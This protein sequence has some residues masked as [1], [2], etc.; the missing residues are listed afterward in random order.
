MSKLKSLRGTYDILP[1]EIEL[2]VYIESRLKK[3]MKRFGYFQIRTP[4]IEK[5]EVFT[6]S[7]GKET[8]IVN[9]EM[10]TFKDVS[11][12]DISL[13]PEATAG[14]VRAYIEHSMYK[15]EEISKFYYFGPMFRKERPQTGRSRQF[16]QFGVEAIGSGN[17]YLDTEIVSI[18]KI[19]FEEIG[20][21]NYNL[22]INTLGCQKDKLYIAELLK[23][24][25]RPKSSKLCREC[26][27][28]V[29]KNVFRVLDCKNKKCIQISKNLPS[30][31]DLICDKCKKHYSDFKQALSLLKIKY[32][33]D[34]TIVRGLDYYTGPVFE[35]THPDLGAQNAIAA[36]GRYDNLVQQMGGPNIEAVGFALGIERL[37][38]CLN[39]K[40]TL[41]GKID[42]FI[43]VVDSEAYE[44][45]F[46]FLYQ[47][48]KRGINSDMDYRT[49]SMKSQM[50]KAGKAGVKY[51][52]LIGKEEL[53][54]NKISIK[55]MITGKQFKAHMDKFLCQIEKLI[56]NRKG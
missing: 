45:A 18:L 40:I 17:P 33:H 28:R 49:S 54:K 22:K 21:N 14:V 43:V 5:T 27:Q 16:Y 1:E 55:D 30:I 35:V 9:K 47:L 12:N 39:R 48:R 51:V 44:C 3:L 37:I 56:K 41:K 26:K 38:L 6:K 13:R 8:D 36:G 32:I 53:D 42:I 31:Q 19:F 34:N 50:R 4:I 52:A 25:L 15:K 2:W 24:K 11:G 23:K 10:Y 7:I 46:K 29:D 20:L